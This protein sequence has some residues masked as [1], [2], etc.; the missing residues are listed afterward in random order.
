M[1]TKLEIM[2]YFCI[3]IESL[4]YFNLRKLSYKFLEFEKAGSSRLPAH[5]LVL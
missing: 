2:M 5:V 1:G 4:A 3:M